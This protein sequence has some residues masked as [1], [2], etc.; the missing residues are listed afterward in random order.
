MNSRQIR[1]KRYFGSIIETALRLRE[2]AQK[3]LEEGYIFEALFHL[4]DALTKEERIFEAYGFPSHYIPTITTLLDQ[5]NKCPKDNR[6][7]FTNCKFRRRN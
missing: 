5:Y 2:K 3:E 4:R 7:W 1:K 6:K